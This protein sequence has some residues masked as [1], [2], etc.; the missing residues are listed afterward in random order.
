M[1]NNL[2][3][4]LLFILVLFVSTANAQ[5]QQF[6]WRLN[7][8][9]YSNV[10]PD[11]VGPANGSVT[12]TLQLHTISATVTSIRVIA[13][14]FSFQSTKAMIP[15]NPGCA[16]V[17][18][19]PANITVGSFFSSS[20]SSVSQC[21]NFVQTIGSNTFD[22]TAAGTLDGL[23]RTISPTWV[24]VFTVTL[25]TLSNTYPQGG[26][27]A[28][29][30]GSTGSPSALGSYSVSVGAV[31]HIVN[32]LTI[33]TPLALGGVLPVTYTSFTAG[34]TDKGALVKWTTGTE[35][36]S[37]Y[38]ELQRSNKDGI[39]WSTVNKV[40][41]KGNSTTETSYEQMDQ[42]GGAALYR[43]KQYDLDGTFHYSN[44]IRTNCADRNIEIVIY[45]VPAR[46]V[47]NIVVRTDKAVKTQLEIYDASGRLVKKINA[48]IILGNN[49]IP[50]S[51]LGLANGQYVIRSTDPLLPLNK[52][53][54]IMH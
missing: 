44:I 30:S 22:R 25:W 41:A 50:V 11:G 38:F 10:D 20:Y 40:K 14:G 51:L 46:D 21:N 7:N 28:I 24:D 9:T 1:K 23:P 19:D 27:V 52:K 12:F 2:T 15:T 32:S 3:K 45:P 8:S 18:D 37:D 34:C 39:E 33:T 49:N 5:I 48:A 47:L 43:L 13:T 31:E 54:T 35:I 36:N 4:I 53:F 16:T 17:I 42:L 26:Y 29:N 6:E